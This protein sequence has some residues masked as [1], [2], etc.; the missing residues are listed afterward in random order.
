MLDFPPAGR[1]FL[2]SISFAAVSQLGPRTSWGCVLKSNFMISRHFS[3]AEVRLRRTCRS[4]AVHQASRAFDPLAWCFPFEIG[5]TARSAPLRHDQAPF[6]KTAANHLI[7][8]TLMEYAIFL[9]DTLKIFLSYLLFFLLADEASEK[10]S[11]YQLRLFLGVYLILK[12][13]CCIFAGVK[14]N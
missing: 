4:S 5:H 8:N 6:W 11:I 3:M 9:P 10:I 14:T 13:E 12:P 1:L 7:Y 2:L